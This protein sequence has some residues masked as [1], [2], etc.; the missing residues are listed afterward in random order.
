MIR[1][2]DWLFSHQV[3]R[4]GQPFS[5]RTLPVW[6]KW[7]CGKLTGHQ[8]SLKWADYMN[9]VHGTRCRCEEGSTD[10]T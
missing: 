1:F 3:G 4:P 5:F 2:F 7:L 6:P 9:D 10:A 8:A